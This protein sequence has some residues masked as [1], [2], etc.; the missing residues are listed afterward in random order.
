[1]SGSGEPD[2]GSRVLL[3][4]NFQLF[5]SSPVLYNFPFS[6]IF[7]RIPAMLEIN[8]VNNQIK[9]MRARLVDLRR[10]L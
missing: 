5:T 3:P 4:F 6:T 1:M 8:A 10:Y 7:Q 9:D 2:S